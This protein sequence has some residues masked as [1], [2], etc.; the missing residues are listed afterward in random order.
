V[1]GNDI[2]KAGSGLTA[3]DLSYSELGLGYVNYFNDNI[4]FMFFYNLVQNETSKNLFGY[5]KDLKDNV[6]TLRMQV[7][8]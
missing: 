4:K 2:G 1:A 6:L 7:R 8:F 3:T 5:G